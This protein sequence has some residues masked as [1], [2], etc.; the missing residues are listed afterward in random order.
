M[1]KGVPHSAGDDGDE[2]KKRGKLNQS[3]PK[4]INVNSLAKNSGRVC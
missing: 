2:L 1:F 4:L 3:E